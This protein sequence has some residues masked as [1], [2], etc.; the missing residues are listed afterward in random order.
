VIKYVVMPRDDEEGPAPAHDPWGLVAMGDAYARR[1]DPAR[2][3][4]CH[5]RAAAAGNLAALVRIGELDEANLVAR[6]Q[7]GVPPAMVALGYLCEQ[8]EQLT[9]AERWYRDAAESGDV[10][11]M[12][13]LADR[14]WSDDSREEWTSERADSARPWLTRAAETGDADAAYQLG[15]YLIWHWLLE[16]EG[17]A[18]LLRAADAGHAE[19]MNELGDR[20]DHYDE[21]AEAEE[22][23]RRA[24]AA[25]SVAAMG[26]LSV[27][28]GWRG[29]VAE[30]AEWK[31]R[32]RL[33]EERAAS[34]L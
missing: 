2:A 29:D 13:R 6:A 3:E 8:R 25:G 10:T 5:R 22:W 9:D 16:D 31:E 30:S 32:I 11:A 21:P 17:R 33:A 34:Q 4:R 20:H 24:A 19:A 27:I 1:G 23:W 14:L 26:S 15:Y 18:W 28:L 7:D 12:G